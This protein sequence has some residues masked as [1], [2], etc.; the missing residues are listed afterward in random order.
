MRETVTTF[1][2]DDVLHNYHIVAN[3]VYTG[4]S[5]APLGSIAFDEFAEH[6]SVA[7]N[8]LRGIVH[9]LGTYTSLVGAPSVR[10]GLNC[11]L[12]AGG[13]NIG[14]CQG[15][16]AQNFPQLST[17]Y[18]SVTTL[19]LDSTNAG[20][21]HLTG[22]SLLTSGAM[23]A[24]TLTQPT[25]T[26]MIVN[27]GSVHGT[28]TDTGSAGNFSLFPPTP[29]GWS[30]TDAAHDQVFTIAVVDNTTRNSAATLKRISTGETLASITLDQSGTGT[31]IY[32]DG[33]SAP[34]T[35]WMLSR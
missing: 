22:T 12:G 31:I 6:V 30:V 5:G 26:T 17:A 4:P 33:A 29:T 13:H 21:L 27:G 8:Q 7:N 3:A 28:T 15:G 2:A 35:G 14:I 20:V 10:L 25:S 24:L 34:V 18:G 9:G 1:T 32:S 16:I 11:D 23:N 19:A